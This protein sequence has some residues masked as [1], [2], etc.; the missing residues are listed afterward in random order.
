MIGSPWTGRNRAINMRL[1]IT[2]VLSL[3]GALLYSASLSAVNLDTEIPVS[4]EQPAIDRQLLDL[5]ETQFHQLIADANIP[6]AAFVVVT[7]QHIAKLATTGHTVANGSESVTAD[8]VFRLASVSKSFAAELTALLVEQGK[9]S[10]E[11]PANR[12]TPEFQIQGRTQSITLENLLGQSTGI[13]GHAY[14][15]L[16]EAG[17]SVEQILPKFAELKPVCQP[18]TCYTYQNVAFSLIEPAIESASEASYAENL[19]RQIFKPLNMRTASVGLEALEQSDQYARPHRK[20]GSRW[21]EV[22]V[23]PTYYRINPAAG[24]NASILDMARW[25]QAQL[26]ANPGVISEQVISSVTAPR[27]ATRKDLRRKFWRDHITDAHYGLGWRV[28]RWGD[29]ELIY[30]GGWVSGFRADI[31]FSPEHQIGFALLMNAEGST[32]SEIT[33]SFWDQFFV[34]AGAAQTSALT[35]SP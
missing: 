32:A 23:L 30:H 24:V 33:T 3:L 28:Y 27:I 21:V 15:H 11:E 4:L 12:F 9:L 34:Q 18:G 29:R 20:R 26:G 31:A 17:K 10:W 7:P 5:F 2:C 16:I 1:S 14:D 19:D 35:V 13:V 25:L 22:P 6:G 8:T